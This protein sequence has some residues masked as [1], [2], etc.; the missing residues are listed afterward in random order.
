MEIRVS[1]PRSPRKGT[2]QAIRAALI[3]IPWQAS[4]QRLTRNI[5]STSSRPAGLALLLELRRLVAGLFL[6]LEALL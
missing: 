4:T 5:M 2:R 1:A 6:G 3:A